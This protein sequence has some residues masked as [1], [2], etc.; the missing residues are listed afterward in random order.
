MTKTI[1]LDIKKI[2]L[3]QGH[4]LKEINLKRKFNVKKINSAKYTYA[5]R[6]AR[7]ASSGDYEVYYGARQLHRALQDGRATIACQVLKTVGRRD[8]REMF[9]LER[10]LCNLASPLE[11]GKRFA[12]F[13]ERYDLNQLDLSR[14]LGISPGTVH[15][16][17]SL[18]VN[19]EGSLIKELEKGRLKFKEARCIA[20]LNSHARQ[21]AVA[22]PFIDGRL[23]SVHVEKLVGVARALAAIP[24][25]KIVAKFIELTDGGRVDKNAEEI[26]AEIQRHFTNLHSAEPLENR[27]LKLA[28]EL[29]ELT[30]QKIPETKKLKYIS[31]LRILDSR[32]QM[33]L[34][35]LYGA[36][37]AGAAEERRETHAD[38]KSANY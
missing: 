13:R 5:P 22:Q 7:D 23:S 2:K 3:A 33:A 31:G 16:Y 17:E 15:H 10:Y 26:S 11:L 38:A 27:I 8:T 6:V 37:T 29:A 12:V 36:E 34:S 30:L 1:E 19:L 24:A 32:L 4:P 20:D 9:L 35:H 21:C 18:A 14:K 25:A 28:G